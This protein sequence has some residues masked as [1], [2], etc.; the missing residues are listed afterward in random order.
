MREFPLFTLCNDV[1]HQNKNVVFVSGFWDVS[2]TKHYLSA[3]GYSLIEHVNVVTI[4][5]MNQKAF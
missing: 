3:L 4:P 5:A 2:N 1:Y